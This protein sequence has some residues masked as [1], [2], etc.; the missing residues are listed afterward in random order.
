M[1]ILAYSLNKEID[2]Q[3][4][5][6]DIQSLISNGP[7]NKDLILVIKVKEVSIDINELIPKIEYKSETKV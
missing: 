5:L 7:K 2:G 1:S 3:Q 4:I 6:R